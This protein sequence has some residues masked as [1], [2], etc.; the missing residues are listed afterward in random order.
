MSEKEGTTLNDQNLSNDAILTRLSNDIIV[1]YFRYKD[2]EDT[3]NTFSREMSQKQVRIPPKEWLKEKLMFFLDKI[4]RTLFQI[5]SRHIIKRTYNSPYLKRAKEL[6]FL[7]RVH[8]FIHELHNDEII[9]PKQGNANAKNKS[10]YPPS[11]TSKKKNKYKESKSKVTPL[12]LFSSYLNNDGKEFAEY[13]EFSRFFALGF[14]SNVKNNA[15]YSAILSRDW[16]DA[17]KYRLNVIIDEIPEPLLFEYIRKKPEVNSEQVQ[18]FVEHDSI[19]VKKQ[20]TLE[21]L[22]QSWGSLSQELYY[23]INAMASN[24]VLDESYCKLLGKRL[25]TLGIATTDCGIMIEAFGVSPK[26][27]LMGHNL[28]N[29]GDLIVVDNMDVGNI[30]ASFVNIKQK[31]SHRH[32]QNSQKNMGHDDDIEMIEYHSPM[33]MS[34]KRVD[35]DNMVSH[36]VNDKEIPILTQLKESNVSL[37][38]P[39][40]ATPPSNSFRESPRMTLE[41][42]RSKITMLPYNRKTIGLIT[43]LRGKLSLNQT[44]ENRQNFLNKLIKADILSLNDN[45]LHPSFFNDLLAQSEVSLEF[46]ASYVIFLHTIVASLEGRRYVCD[47]KHCSVLVL[48]LIEFVVETSNTNEI[49]FHQLL[50]ILQRLSVRENVCQDLIDMGIVEWCIDFLISTYTSDSASFNLLFGC[51]LLYNLILRRKGVEKTLEN[52]DKFCD[53]FLLLLEIDLDECIPFV[54]GCFYT[55]LGFE[56]VREKMKNTE[57]VQKIQKIQKTSG[58]EHSEQIKYVLQRLEAKEDI[59]DDNPIEDTDDI[60]DDPSTDPEVMMFDENVQKVLLQRNVNVDRLNTPV[61][62]VPR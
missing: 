57:F 2:F 59:F 10:K 6:E 34:D 39:R 48:T 38:H 44:V 29:D 35:N 51:A 9:F 3:I 13:P 49:L 55:M 15:L 19:L 50:S 7:L 32:S 23:I 30:L 1:D 16:L 8:F 36:T 4:D 28:D 12:S 46:T 56:K 61:S 20:R 60:W 42:I 45:N 24:G 25:E 53:I 22:I 18:H 27:P 62:A 11:S 54:L 5:Y 41:E 58:N 40:K 31:N 33:P 37:F 43:F 21:G 14:D 47:S 17:L 26:T 52:L